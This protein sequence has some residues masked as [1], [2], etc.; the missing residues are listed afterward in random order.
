VS[1]NGKSHGYFNCSRGVRQG[2]P[3]S[4]LI[5]CLAEDVLSRSI[6]KLVSDGKLYI[7]KGTRNFM[8][9]SHSFYADDL[10]I[11]CKGTLSGLKALKDL[12]TAYALESGQV[13]NT[14]KSTIYPGSIS[15]GRLNLIV[16][17][18]ILT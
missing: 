6:S 16:Q 17:L 11:F 4:P 10:M 9:P 15:H 1:I 12:F 8:V 5:F 2:D 18:L 14:S 3:L 13:I 7:I